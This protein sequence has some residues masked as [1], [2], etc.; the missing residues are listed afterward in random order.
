MWVSDELIDDGDNGFQRFQGPE[1]SYLNTGFNNDSWSA[2]PVDNQQESRHYA[3]WVPFLEDSGE[4][5]IEMFIP[6]GVE[7]STEAIYEISVRNS[8]GVSSRTDVTV[9]Q[10]INP[11]SFEIIA[12]LDLPAGS[13]SAVVLR[14]IVGESSGG[15][16]V[17]FDAIRF[18]PNFTTSILDDYNNISPTMIRS[19][20]PNP[21]NS[22]TIIYYETAIGGLVVVEIMNALGQS[23]Y[24]AQLY[25][26]APGVHSHIWNGENS[27][28]EALPSGV[29][30][31]LLSNQDTFSSKK[32]LYLK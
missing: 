23:V 7:A 13:R 25:N 2:P 27:L 31:V 18:T 26:K 1:W 22:S 30:L 21:F 5:N 24:N 9:D 28:G 14:D 19:I 20:S 29:Y 32:I 12:T 6:D 16:S 4:Y 17:V 11:G 15:S 8:N 3:I 10:N